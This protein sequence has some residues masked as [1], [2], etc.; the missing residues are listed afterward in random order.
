MVTFLWHR[1]IWSQTGFNGKFCVFWRK[2]FVTK[3]HRCQIFGVWI[4]TLSGQIR[5]L[6]LQNNKIDRK[7]FFR[8]FLR[9]FFRRHFYQYMFLRPSC[10]ECIRIHYRTILRGK[11]FRNIWSVS[12]GRIVPLF[13]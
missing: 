6:L 4:K 7:L 5:M 3:N 13:G 9:L 1:Q 12:F 8:I 2:P 11:L 10:L